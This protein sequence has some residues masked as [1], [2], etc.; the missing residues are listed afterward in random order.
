MYIHLGNGKI[1]R[2][3]EMIGIFDLDGA[4]LSKTTR[5][6]LSKAEKDG[7]LEITLEDLPKSIILTDKKVYLSFLSAKALSG[8]L[9]AERKNDISRLLNKENINE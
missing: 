6:F 8:R 3:K 4:T 9:G 5:A 1:A 2:E 7:V